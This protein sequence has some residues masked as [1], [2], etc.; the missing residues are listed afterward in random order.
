MERLIEIL[1]EIAPGVDYDTCTTLIDDQILDSF[2]MLSLISEI[3]DVFGVET[4]PTEL[5]PENFNSAQSIWE[6]ICRL[7][8][9]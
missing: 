2:G 9:E 4:D 3:E 7:I 6:M 5:I 1:E 8:E